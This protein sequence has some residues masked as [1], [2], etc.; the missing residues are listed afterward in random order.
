[1]RYFSNFL[2]LVLLFISLAPELYAQNN[3]EKV[4]TGIEIG[5]GLSVEI[6][7][8][9]YVTVVLNSYEPTEQ[10]V[11]IPATFE[12]ITETKVI[13]EAYSKLDISPPVYGN[14]GS[15]R[16]AAKAKISEVPAATIEVS[17]RIVKTPQRVVKRLVPC[18]CTPQTTR[19]RTKGEVYI[20]R[21]QNGVEIERYENPIKLAEFINAN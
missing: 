4:S 16:I 21:N 12:T 17:K 14:D 8:A 6:L 5:N 18:M 20:I 11:T 9:T 3:P 7:P 1:M 13:Q 2:L 19:K 15:I 10:W